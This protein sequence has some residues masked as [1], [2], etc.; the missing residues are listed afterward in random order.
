MLVMVGE[1]KGEGE[2]RREIF[3]S[4]LASA[5]FKRRGGA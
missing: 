2:G 3:E 4:V 1:G 5:G